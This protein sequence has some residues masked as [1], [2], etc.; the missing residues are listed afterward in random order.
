MKTTEKK[1]TTGNKEKGNFEEWT[2][3]VTEYEKGDLTVSFA[4]GVQ[5]LGEE[6]VLS[7]I[8]RQLA[9]DIANES[10]R[11]R[12]SPAKRVDKESMIILLMSPPFNL[13]KEDAEAK[14]AEAQLAR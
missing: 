14:V 8:N 11:E 1:V 2:I 4:S 10:R 13:S 5:A 6:T 7:L 9:T 3:K 12:T